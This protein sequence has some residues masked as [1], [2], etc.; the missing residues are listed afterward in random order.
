MVRRGYGESNG[1]IILIGEHA[2]T[3]G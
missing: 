3:F 1:K 2:V